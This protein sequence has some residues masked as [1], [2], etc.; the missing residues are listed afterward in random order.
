MTRSVYDVIVDDVEPKR[1]EQIQEDFGRHLVEQRNRM[2]SLVRKWIESDTKFPVPVYDRLIDR[3]RQLDAATRADIASVSLL[4]A[5]EIVGAVLAVFARGD[6][7]FV[8]SR[9]ANY[10]VVAQ[11]RRPGSDD[12]VEEVDVN[13]G[14][15]V[16]AI[17]DRYKRWLSRYAPSELRA[18]TGGNDNSATE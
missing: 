13:R 7:M 17:W 4:M 2:A 5:D 1:R 14:K 12:V 3:V 18:R 15:P 9:L 11:F 10:A 8:D 6:E 16:I